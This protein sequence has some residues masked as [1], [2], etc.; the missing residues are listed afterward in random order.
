[1]KQIKNW[2]LSKIY[3]GYDKDFL[4]MM[5]NLELSAQSNWKHNL[6]PQDMKDYETYKS[7]FLGSHILAFK[8]GAKI[9]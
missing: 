1:M 8:I 4:A 6:R 5:R 7:F 3:W 2:I 9:K